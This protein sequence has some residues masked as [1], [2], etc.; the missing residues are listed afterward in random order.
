MIHFEAY[1]L[2]RILLEAAQATLQAG[3]V[4]GL[5]VANMSTVGPTKARQSGPAVTRGTKK[6]LHYTKHGVTLWLR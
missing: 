1:K 6:T 5:G 4:E 3:E 2:P